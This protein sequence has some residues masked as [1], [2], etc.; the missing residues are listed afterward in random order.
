MI[1][2][3]FIIDSET[4]NNYF[5]LLNNLLFP[6]FVRVSDERVERGCMCACVGDNST[7]GWRM[8]CVVTRRHF[9]KS[10]V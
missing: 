1:I 3:L 4:D 7:G 2:L 6:T 5:E 10:A 8:A 9:S